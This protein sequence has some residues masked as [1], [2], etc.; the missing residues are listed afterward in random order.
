MQWESNTSTC[1]IYTGMSCIQLGLCALKGRDFH[2][3]EVKACFTSAGAKYGTLLT[4]STYD[5]R[6]KLI[7]LS[8]IPLF[9]AEYDPSAGGKKLKI[10]CHFFRRAHHIFSISQMLGNSLFWIS[11][12]SVFL[13]FVPSL[14]PWPHPLPG[15]LFLHSVLFY[16]LHLFPADLYADWFLCLS[17][18]SEAAIVNKYCL[19][20]VSA[21]THT[22]Q[23]SGEN[24]V[25][26]LFKLRAE[27]TWFLLIIDFLCQSLLII[28]KTCSCD[29]IVHDW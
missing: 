19:S 28:R 12:I 8:H 13:S 2:S 21:Q 5:C 10:F 14:H 22:Q 11:V 20:S 17:L 9:N 26:L 6:N 25:F 3:G 18:S 24:L 1:L 27:S 23:E 16:A 4:V 15:F 29:I 7:W